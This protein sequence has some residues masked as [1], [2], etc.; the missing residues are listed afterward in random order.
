MSKDVKHLEFQLL[1]NLRQLQVTGRGGEGRGGEREGGEGRGWE[2]EGQT[3]GGRGE[4]KP[5]EGKER[6]GTI[7]GNGQGRRKG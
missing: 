1:H 5:H 7:A 6:E 2:S 3:R 4:E